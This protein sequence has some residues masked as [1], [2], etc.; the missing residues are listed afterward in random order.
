VGAAF[1]WIKTAQNLG[2]PNWY[3]ILMFVP[4]VNLFILWEMAK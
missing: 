1:F 3:G 4:I 2:K